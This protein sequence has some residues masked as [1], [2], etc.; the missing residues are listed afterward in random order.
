VPVEKNQDG[1]AK[2]LVILGTQWQYQ[3]G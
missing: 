3:A 1:N 2:S